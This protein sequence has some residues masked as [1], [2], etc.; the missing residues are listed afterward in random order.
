MDLL[1]A[2]CSPG[3]RPRL[4][5]ARRRDSQARLLQLCSC[6]LKPADAASAAGLRCCEQVVR[7]CPRHAAIRS[8]GCKALILAEWDHSED[9]SLLWAP[10]GEALLACT[11]P[12]AVGKRTAM[13]CDNALSM[14]CVKSGKCWAMQLPFGAMLSTIVW[15]PDLQLLLALGV[16]R[17]PSW[18]VSPVQ[19][20]R[21]S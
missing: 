19:S 17:C 8:V 12:F 21:S 16:T 1:W 10:D 11:L 4:A 13:R 18:T 5:Y 6:A 3:G 2:P 9:V 14:F 7:R 20:R 15:S